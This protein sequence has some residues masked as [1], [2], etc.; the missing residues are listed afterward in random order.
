MVLISL[1]AP[2]P[3]AA[4]LSSPCPASTTICPHRVTL[5]KPAESKAQD[6]WQRGLG[7]P[8]FSKP[9]RWLQAQP[10][11]GHPPPQTLKQNQ[12]LAR[13]STLPPWLRPQGLSGL[14]KLSP[15]EHGDHS[16]PAPRPHLPSCL[17]GAH[18]QPLS[19]GR[20]R[21]VGALLW[22]SF[23][24]RK[25]RFFPFLFFLFNMRVPRVGLEHRGTQDT[26]VLVLF[27]HACWQENM[28]F[29]VSWRL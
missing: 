26:V 29:R 18:P 21:T 25:M 6:P 7:E 24:Q 4:S 14:G 22:T 23:Q 5:E 20:W 15:R 3:R 17:P 8:K 10:A 12:T 9:H 27:W 16:A 1:G 28:V 11:N 13:A 2:R 19:P